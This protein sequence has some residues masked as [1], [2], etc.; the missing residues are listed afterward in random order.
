MSMSHPRAASALVRL[1]A[2]LTIALSL[3]PALSL[4]AGA[5][6]PAADVARQVAEQAGWADHVALEFDGA[7]MVVRSNGLPNH[8][9]LPVYQALSLTDNKTVYRIQ[10][11]EQR[12]R[13]VM[14]L[15]PRLAAAKT[16]TNIG[17]IGIAI[18]GAVIYSP[19][20]ADGTTLALDGNFVV[21]SIPFVDDCNGHPNPLGV[22]YHYHG[23]PTCITSVIDRPGEHSRLFG[24]LLDGFA[25]YGPQDAG[26]ARIAPAQLDECSG[27]VGPTPEHPSGIYHYHMTYEA[28]YSIPCYSGEIDISPNPLALLTRG[29]DLAPPNS[30]DLGWSP[31]V[32][33]LLVLVLINGALFLALRRLIK[34]PWLAGAATVLLSTVAVELWA[35]A[36]TGRWSVLFILYVLLAG[37]GTT[38]GISLLA[39]LLRRW[40]ARRAA[41]ALAA[42]A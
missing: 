17:I 28:P 30:V 19:F 1:F 31:Y 4:S 20:E 34:R 22:Q 15:Q 37:V 8:R 40:R 12:M 24:Y 11:K 21:D 5:Q 18:S 6:T 2:A 29:V 38:V 33:G 23:I 36:A 3:L 35:Y 9:L 41:P 42:E 10:P 13:V 32:P 39:A 16:P 14:P 27:H 26:G 25:V 7:T